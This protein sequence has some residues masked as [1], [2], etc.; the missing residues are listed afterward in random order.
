VTRRS[1]LVSRPVKRNKRPLSRRIGR[2]LQRGS[3]ALFSFALLL[4]FAG[5]LSLGFVMLYQYLLKAPYF[6]LTELA[7]EGA[8]PAM[9]KELIQMA[10]LDVEIS[11]LAL[12]LDDIRQRM[13]IHPWV[14]KVEMQRRFPRGLHVKVEKRVPVALISEGAVSYVDANG[15][16]FKEV[17]PGEDIHYPLLSGLSDKEETRRSRIQAALALLE[18]LKGHSEILSPERISEIHFKGGGL[19]SIYLT[20]MKAEI[21]VDANRLVSK[22]DELGRVLEHLEASGRKEQ[23]SAIDLSYD[24]GVVVSFRKG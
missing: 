17:E 19:A 8:E 12:D 14:R 5:A 1:R 18:I 7:F 16:V 2:A 22:I 20:D 24:E 15:E 13:E 10:G 11:T 21:K 23:A 9:E 4:T 6:R 3:F